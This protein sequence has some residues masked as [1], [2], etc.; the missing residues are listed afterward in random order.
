MTPHFTSSMPS[1]LRQNSGNSALISSPVTCQP[2]WRASARKVPMPQPTSSIRRP[3]A[4]PN[5]DKI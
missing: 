3:F 2:A 5:S 4:G 1:S